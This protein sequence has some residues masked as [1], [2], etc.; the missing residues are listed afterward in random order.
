MN[1]FIRIQ[2]LIWLSPFLLFV[3]SIVSFVFFC[4]LNDFNLDIV[5]FLKRKV[6]SNDSLFNWHSVALRVL[7]RVRD[8]TIFFKVTEPFK[9]TG[10][11]KGKDSASSGNWTPISN[12][13]SQIISTPESSQSQVEEKL[14]VFLF[15][16][17]FVNF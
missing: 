10:D 15:Y 11:N 17:I 14:Q 4:V 16:V 8:W 3:C 5:S 6:N 12:L 7:W 13:E 2:F 1:K 9:E